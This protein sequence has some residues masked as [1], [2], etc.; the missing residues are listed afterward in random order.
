[1]KW[2]PAR[3]GATETGR[4]IFAARDMAVVPSES[5]TGT[6]TEWMSTL[7]GRKPVP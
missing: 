1:M 2:C 3:E 7:E 6:A 5:S 4:W